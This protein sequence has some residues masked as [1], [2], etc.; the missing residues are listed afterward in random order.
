MAATSRRPRPDSVIDDLTLGLDTGPKA[1]AGGERRTEARAAEPG[2][3][4]RTDGAA[5][6]NP[7]PASCGAV[8]I[9]LGRPDSHHP[10]ARPDASISDYLGIR[11]NNVAEYT[12]VARAVRLAAELGARRVELLLDSKLIVEQLAGRWRVKDAK[13]QPLWADTLRTLRSFPGGWTGAHVPR[14][15]NSQADALANVAI[16]RVLS[17]GPE[18]VVI[19]PR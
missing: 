10:S 2:F 14:A 18:S 12:G 19:R 4:I 11:T 15:Q 5:R 1:D 16:D 17:G 13:L 6:G 9:A 7:G 8:L 3:V